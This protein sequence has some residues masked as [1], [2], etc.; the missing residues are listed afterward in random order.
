MDAYGASV[1]AQD[2][3]CHPA[4]SHDDTVQRLQQMDADLGRQRQRRQRGAQLAHRRVLRA[5]RPRR[6]LR[7]T[8]VVRDQLGLASPTQGSITERR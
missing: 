3:D 7:P 5:D 1:R 8:A 6:W 4:G 2:V